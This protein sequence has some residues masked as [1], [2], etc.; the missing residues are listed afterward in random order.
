MHWRAGAKSGREHCV[1]WRRW[2]C[3]ES[4]CRLV[5]MMMLLLASVYCRIG[6]SGSR[7]VRLSW[8]CLGSIC[9]RLRRSSTSNWGLSELGVGL[10]CCCWRWCLWHIGSGSGRVESEDGRAAR[11]TRLLTLEPGSQAALV[12]N[13]IAR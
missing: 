12:K 10:C 2:R 13:V 4:T 5:M 9:S 8:L 3:K 7:C 11:W 6:R 1:R